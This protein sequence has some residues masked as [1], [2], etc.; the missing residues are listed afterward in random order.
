MLSVLLL[1]LGNQFKFGQTKSVTVIMRVAFFL[2]C[3]L[4]YKYNRW[5]HTVMNDISVQ[6]PN[7]HSRFVV[8]NRT[9]KI[10]RIGVY[11]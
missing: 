9:K 7:A 11:L 2:E 3:V 10:R 1:V 6:W 4:F 8:M 5:T